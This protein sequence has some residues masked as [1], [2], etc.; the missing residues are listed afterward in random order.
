MMKKV[1]L[2]VL[3]CILVSPY[4]NAQTIK[5]TGTVTDGKDALPGVT[6]RIKASNSGTATD[7]KGKF[8]IN[9]NPNATL[10][11]SF[12]G[13]AT[14]EIK[15]AGQTNI[16]VK[17]EP[18]N[19]SLQETVIIGYQKVTRKTT[20][21]AISSVSG[22]E[23][24]NLPAASFDQLLQGRLSG[25]NVQNFTGMPGA[26]S[27]VSVRGNSFVGSA[28]D[29]NRVTNSP[30]YVV[31]GVPQPSEGYT[32]P[33]GGTGSNY[34]AGI[35][36][37]DIESVD[38]LK[39]A[40]AAAIYGSR[41]AN[42]VILI[43]TKKGTT[44]KNRVNLSIYGGMTQRPELR[45]V[46]LGVTERR[47]KMAI[48]EGL[49]YDQ[50]KQLPYIMTD[51]LNPAFN[52]NTNWQEIFYQTAFIK[53]ADLGLSGGGEN[54][55][56]R[57]SVGYYDEEGIIKGTGFSRYTARLNLT[58]HALDNKL[59]INP[60]I[61]YY[62]SDRKRGSGNENSPISLSAGSM[63]ASVIGLDEAKKATMLG[64]YDASLDK[65][66]D[67]NLTFNL[68]LGYA[69]SDHFRFTSMNSYI[70]QNARRDRSITSQVSGDGQNA[71]YTFA[72]SRATMLSSNYFSYVNN[73]AGNN[74]SAVLGTEVS[75]DQYQATEAAG[76]R[77]VSDQIQVIGGFGKD[78]LSVGSNY[79]AYG[80]LSYYARLAYDYKEKYLLSMSGR[81]DGSSKF[82]KDNK[83][84]FFPSA[85]V[86]WLLSEENILKDSRVFSLV[87]VRASV[88][89]SGSLPD[90]NYLQYNLYN[91]NNGWYNG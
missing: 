27:S 80:L 85:S 63:P 70:Y 17:L 89:T 31:D 90:D 6:V 16:S 62:R 68:N 71:S 52:N 65:N 67:N 21:A 28:Y 50:K 5:V 41:A 9:V 79:Q 82:G 73:F 13:Y 25:V 56:Y 81:F 72:S 12:I 83:W 40:S 37:V 59:D 2:F 10:E 49:T 61:S 20:T 84:G 88:G 23:L 22:K 64:A 46:T 11:V 14:K 8:S 38:V 77:G 58:T 4:V 30:L 26:R 91:V 42:G 24:Q 60:I 39:D 15:L 66:V 76:F 36:P 69:F 74:L 75:F 32:G 48:A 29:E 45:D 86:A 7:E 57:F 19:S 53:N 44:G 51:S 87:K 1:Y 34:L 55:S 18:S 43:T 54:S 33:M 78:N 35:N 47:Q 3:L